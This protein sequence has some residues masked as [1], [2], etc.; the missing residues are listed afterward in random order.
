[1]DRGWS[2]YHSLPCKKVPNRMQQ[3]VV[4]RVK[5]ARLCLEAG[6][7]R[8]EKYLRCPSTI[9]SVLMGAVGCPCAC[10]KICTTFTLCHICKTR[11]SIIDT[12]NICSTST[13]LYALCQLQSVS[14]N[15]HACT[16][17][18]CTCTSQLT[19]SAS[20]APISAICISSTDCC[21]S[22]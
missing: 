7:Y 19:H 16:I 4:T 14:A 5:D 10:R 11:T 20:S 8:A 2:H 3:N 21:R 9:L 12:H 6:P 17:T 15:A 1:M 18:S 13:W 22:R